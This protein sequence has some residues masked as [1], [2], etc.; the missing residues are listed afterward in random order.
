MKF[1]HAKTKDCAL[2]AELNHQLIRDEGHRNPMTV[3]Q[4][5]ERMRGWLV[6]GY[7]AVLFQDGKDIVAYALYHE[8]PEKI[9]L[10]HLF[11]VRHRRRQGIGRKVV[12][13]LRTKIWPKDKRLT[14]DVLVH[15][16]SAVA[17]WR[18]VGYQ[19]YALTLEILPAA[20]M[21]SSKSP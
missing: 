9:Y 19:D 17:F 8:S 2:L 16:T 11:V 21:T 5:Q 6:E 12:A 7:T 3:T 15:N 18:A 13:L 14:V 10:R 1:R 4:L 20:S